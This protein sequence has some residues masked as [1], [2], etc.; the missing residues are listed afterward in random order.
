MYSVTLRT[1][2]SRFRLSAHHLAIETGRHTK[3][4]TPADKRFCL[5]CHDGCVQDEMHHLL[6]CQPLES[7]RKPLLECASK[8]IPKFNVLSACDK[9][10]E[11][12]KSDNS[13][14]LTQLGIFFIQA[15]KDSL[16]SHSRI[17]S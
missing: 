7:Y 5:V 15:D 10:I 14:L 2:I 3:P 6:M 12:M 17:S 9:F 16:T 13:D 8:V 1:A 4:L 11:I